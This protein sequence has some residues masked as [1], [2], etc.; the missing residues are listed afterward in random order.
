M[1]PNEREGC[2][3]GGHLGRNS[4][5]HSDELSTA[6]STG[7]GVKP[8]ARVARCFAPAWCTGAALLVLRCKAGARLT[9][10]QNGTA[11]RQ[12]K[13]CTSTVLLL[14]KYCTATLLT[15]R[16]CWTGTVLCWYDDGAIFIVCLSLRSSPVVS[17]RGGRH[18]LKQ[19]L[20]YI[21]TTGR[22][23]YAVTCR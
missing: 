13:S 4:T 8:K 21:P 19:N 15:L 18:V 3:F 11:R 20:G 10:G 7:S 22:N 16:W 2:E 6:G 17:R 9:Q 23:L 1:P 5:G 12:T 14:N